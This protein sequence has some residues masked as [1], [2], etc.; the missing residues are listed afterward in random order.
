MFSRAA[1]VYEKMLAPPIEGR[2]NSS[3][4]AEVLK[5]LAEALYVTRSWQRGLKWFRM[6]LDESQSPDD[7]ALAAAALLEANINLQNYDDALAYL[8]F[9]I[10][11]SP[12]RYKLQLNVALIDAGDKL[13][14]EKRYA[15]AMLMYRMVLTVDEIIEWQ[16]AHLNSLEKQLERLRLITSDRNNER[17][18]QLETE[19]FNTKAQLEALDTLEPY[20][21]ALKVRIARNYLL[22]YRDWE[23]FYAYMIIIEEYPDHENYE[24]F[25]YAAFS[26]AA[27]VGKGESVIELGER[28][29]ENEDFLNYRDD[30]IVKL[31]EYYRDRQ[32]FDEFF[33]LAKSFVTE[34]PE[35][36][37]ASSVIFLMGSTYAQLNRFQEMIDQFQTWEKAYPNTKMDPGLFYWI[38]L[39]MI[40]ESDYEGAWEYF[41]RVVNDFPNN[42][43]AQDS[44]YRRG[45]CYMGFEEY[46]AA[47]RDFDE[48]VRKYPDTPLR[49]EV[50]YFLGEIESALGNVQSA[51]KHYNN[52]EKY[53]DNIAFIQNAYFQMGVLLEANKQYSEMADVFLRFIDRFADQGELTG[54]I[55][56]LG[57][58]YELD[59]KPHLA[60]EQY[61]E[62]IEEFGDDPYTYGLDDILKAHPEKYYLNQQLLA[63]NIDLLNKLYN[64]RDFR[65]KINQD[66]QWLFNYIADKPLIRENI[67]R[68]LYQAE[69]RANL[70][71]NPE[72]L[73]EWIQ[74]FNELQAVFP[75]ETPEELFTA[76]YEEAREN[77]E[78]TLALRLQ[79][80]IDQ[81]GNDVDP[82]RIF[83]EDD[84]FYASPV[85]LIWIGKRLE[86]YDRNASRSAYELVITDHPESD[87]VFN[88][89]VALGDLDFE[90]GEVDEALIKYQLAEA[91]YPTH[92]N[93]V[94]TLMK[95]GNAY[96]S[97]REYDFARE[98]FREVV[99]NRD[100]RGEI[101]AEAL[102]KIGDSFMQQGQLKQAQAFYER[103]YIGYPIYIDW[104]SNSYLESGKILIQLGLK[105]QAREVFDEFLANDSYEDTDAYPEIKQ[106]RGTL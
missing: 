81:L 57:R 4:R 68:A 38:G 8:R 102:F 26:G 58:A 66:R 9:L 78:E 65:E 46:D 22:T 29:L 86:R 37:F 72:I 91:E 18:I 27:K 32:D 70:V 31:L 14:N 60:L 11:E 84:F 49:G 83:T 40:L 13:A 94:D 53:T 67:K 79:F 54:A 5:K 104:A 73:D 63:E 35:S 55:F 47:K 62:A 20:T 90:D 80:A 88:A 48:Y 56:Q 99:G 24:D 101:H 87:Q 39:G 64:D 59:L 93:M 6:Y 10:G 43:Y 34:S 61:V 85:V 106:L 7:R 98:K 1:D 36:D 33:Y 103:V 77:A 76:M 45:I 92:V 3:E 97:L 50:E 75:E 69:Y 30:V 15:E 44:L 16:N 96:N 25:L 100:W 23:S 74:E 21:A 41:N 82:D 105:D 12:A 95:Q 19:I 52:V 28:Y 71:D 2:M 17:A 89:L 51:L 42:V